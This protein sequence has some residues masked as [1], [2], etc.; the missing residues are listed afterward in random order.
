MA[1]RLDPVR[2]LIA[3]DVGIGKTVEASL[4]AKELLERGEVNRFAVL[5]PPHLAEQ[6][7]KELSDKF[8]IDAELVLS[9]TV[10]K[11]ERGLAAGESIFDVHPYVIVSTDFIKSIRRRDDF[12][13]ACPELVI[14][15]EAHTCTI[16]GQVGQSRQARFELIRQIAKTPDRHLILVTATPHSGNE[17]AFR[18]LLSLIDAKFSDLPKDLETD[19]R[20]ALRAE[21]AQHLV[22]RLRQEHYRDG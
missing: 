16:S 7:Q 18:S 14:V 1:L 13:R 2:M 19:S 20:S 21:L 6:W 22:Q 9:S 15:D 12:V 17:D 4:I 11:L 10:Q 5:C 3:D 8:H